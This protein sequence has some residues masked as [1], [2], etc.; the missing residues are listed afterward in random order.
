[1]PNTEV[2]PLI[3]SKEGIAHL[4]TA[5][6]DPGDLVLVPDPG[7][8]VYSIGTMLA[9][10][11]VYWLPLQAERG[12]LPGPRRRSRPRWRSGRACCGS[13]TRTIRRPPWR[14]P[15]LLRGGGGLRLGAR[16][17]W[18]ATTTPTPRSPTTATGR[19]AF[20]RSTGAREVGI[21]FHSLS[22]T[23]NMTGWRIGMVVGNRDADRGAGP[24]E[25]ERRQRH[26]P[27]RAVRGVSRRCAA[28][29]RGWRS[30]TCTTSAAA[31]PC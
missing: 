11:E 4:A 13:T 16:H 15:R 3:G 21:E 7:Y 14:R 6:V 26:L 8:P 10:G 25:D 29:R 24:R 27:G 18:S 20:C 23:Y 9:N 17:R 19:R 1:M 22:K 28:T 31:T 12:F 2:L 5:W 30:A